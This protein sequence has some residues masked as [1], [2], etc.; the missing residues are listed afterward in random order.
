MM[1]DQQPLNNNQRNNGF[2]EILMKIVVLG[3]TG[4][5]GHKM[6]QILSSRFDSVIGFAYEDVSKPP[7]DRLELFQG[8]EMI[9]G[10]NAADFQTLGKKLAAVRP[11]YIVN[12]IGIIKQR[13]TASAYIPCIELN[14]LLPH[15]LAT[16]AQKRGG[17]VIHFSTD[18][19]F[20]GRRGGYTEKDFS[21]AEDLYGKSKFL[22]E[23]QGDNALTL[24][25]SIIGRELTTHKS[26]LDWVLSQ[27]GQ[28]VKG[29]K[30]VVYSGV[31]TNQIADVVAMIIEQFPA[32]S[33]LYQVVADPIPK[34]DLLCLIRDAFKLDLEIVP[35]TETVS[36]RSMKGDKLR[37]ATGYVSPSWPELIADLAND[38]T[39]YKEWGVIL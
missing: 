17:R 2:K 8:V 24:R 3:A 9:T 21:D 23:V 31:T 15:K 7:Y 4:M 13:E 16:F 34:H 5:L 33:G 28:M 14:S 25:T 19:V 35:E 36:D 38:P 37:A 11:D 12:C 6:L 27:N 29:F 26:L 22:G 32:L 30:N 18:C 1:I 10:V 39:P 20:D